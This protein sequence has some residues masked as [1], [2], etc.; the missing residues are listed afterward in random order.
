[1]GTSEKKLYAE[2]DIFLNVDFHLLKDNSELKRKRQSEI[3]ILP[4][5]LVYLPN[6]DT[7][8]AGPGQSRSQDRGLGLIWVS[9]LGIKELKPSAAACRCAH[10]RK[11]DQKRVAGTQTGIVPWG[12]WHSFQG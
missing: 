11:L 1:M 9:S 5:S 4:F 10:S 8:W 7:V 3:F 2:G 6:A 12:C